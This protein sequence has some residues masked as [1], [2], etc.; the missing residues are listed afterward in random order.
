MND[1]SALVHILRQLPRPI[2]LRQAALI[3]PQLRILLAHR[4]SRYA[5]AALGFF[6]EVTHLG[7]TIRQSLVS[8]AYSI[9]VDVAGDQ[10]HVLCMECKEALTEIYVTAGLTLPKLT[11]EQKLQFNSIMDNFMDLVS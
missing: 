4:N 1:K 10:R 9:G 3:L 8:N 2:N 5:D 7:D 11:E 6:K